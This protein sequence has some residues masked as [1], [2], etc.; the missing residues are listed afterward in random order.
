MP[1][2]ILRPTLIEE[3][4]SQSAITSRLELPVHPISSSA[5]SDALH[6][7]VWP[8]R[9][10]TVCYRPQTSA[11]LVLRCKSHPTDS[12][13]SRLDELCVAI[14]VVV[15]HAMHMLVSIPYV[16]YLPVHIDE[17]G[18]PSPFPHPESTGISHKAMQPYMILSSAFQPRESV[19][20]SRGLY[21]KDLRL[22]FHS[23]ICC[24]AIH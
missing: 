22:W 7:G 10:C 23:G 17:L 14:L 13:Y 19:H 12:T 20:N 11:L 2:R 9:L 1:P 18:G 4:V 8:T 5:E 16:A 24:P 6:S 3:G 21:A 15:V